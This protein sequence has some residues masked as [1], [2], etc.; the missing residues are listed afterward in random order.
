M[1][2]KKQHKVEVATSAITGVATTPTPAAKNGAVAMG[3]STK[4]T[5]KE[6][7]PQWTYIIGIGKPLQVDKEYRVAPSVAEQLIA[8][9]I[10]IIKQQS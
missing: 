7:A 4:P 1:A 6:Y 3:I 2:K 9:G 5:R 10:A 8:K